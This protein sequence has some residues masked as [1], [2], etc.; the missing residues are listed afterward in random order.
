MKNIGNPEK[1]SNNLSIPKIKKS[2]GSYIK[3]EDGKISKQ[4]LI[5]MGAIIGTAALAS[6]DSVAHGNDHSN[7]I[8]LSIVDE[9]VHG[10]H[11]HHAS[12]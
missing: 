12:Y 10:L 8:Q 4:A 7:N 6:K 1:S 2:I 3:S 11:T 9:S 5:S